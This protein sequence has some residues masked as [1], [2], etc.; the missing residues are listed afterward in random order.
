MLDAKGLYRL[1]MRL[2]QYVGS[3]SFS[4][5][6]LTREEHEILKPPK[7]EGSRATLAGATR[8]DLAGQ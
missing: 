6:Q 5:P 1:E 2:S 4:K 7:K 8:N 3:R